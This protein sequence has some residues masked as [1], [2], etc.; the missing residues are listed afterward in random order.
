MTNTQLK[1]LIEVVI[2]EMNND[3]TPFDKEKRQDDFENGKLPPVDQ[4]IESLPYGEK[5]T[6]IWP[7]SD[8]EGI[9]QHGTGM[10][11]GMGYPNFSFRNKLTRKQLQDILHLTSVYDASEEDETKQSKID[12]EATYNFIQKNMPWVFNFKQKKEFQDWDYTN[13]R[14]DPDMWW[15]P[16]NSYFGNSVGFSNW[17][18]EF[19]NKIQNQLQSFIHWRD[20]DVKQ[21][22]GAAKHNPHWIKRFKEARD[23]IKRY[24]TLVQ[25]FT[26]LINFISKLN[27]FSPSNPLNP[28]VYPLF[29]SLYDT[30]RRLGGHEEGGWW[31]DDYE[32]IQSIQVKNYQEA[33]KVAVQLLRIMDQADMNG[34]PYIILEKDQGGQ[35]NKQP[36]TYS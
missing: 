23:M 11:H 8:I 24:P 10:P 20:F 28:L 7:G 3:E 17:A 29:V 6:P 25:D 30:S 15:Y 32:L 2:R 5:T 26:K 1:K 19:G 21:L 13:N 9:K 36:P 22:K 35:G 31:Y 33:R 12:Q 18:L 34:K 4:E 14:P 16:F 27:D